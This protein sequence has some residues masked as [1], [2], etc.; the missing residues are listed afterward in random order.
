MCLPVCVCVCVQIYCQI[1]SFPF[2]PVIYILLLKTNLFCS[3]YS[4]AGGVIHGVDIDTSY[5]TGN[6]APRVS[7]QAA[8][9]D[10][11]M[12]F[13]DD[14]VISCCIKLQRYEVLL[15]ILF[16]FCLL[17]SLTDLPGRKGDR[18]GQG[19]NEK[20]RLMVDKLNSE[21]MCQSPVLCL[22][23]YQ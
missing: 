4:G 15:K 1:P 23:I 14:F 16:C 21:V 17:L 19:E 2:T 6:F 13:S 7:I 22:T 20:E 9:L 18:I 12:D 11:G 10:E 8:A 5:F 3:C